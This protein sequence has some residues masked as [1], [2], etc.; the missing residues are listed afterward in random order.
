MLS[1]NAQ[2]HMIQMLD[3]EGKN[4]RKR[5]IQ[6]TFSHPVRILSLAGYSDLK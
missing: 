2:H 3:G 4:T 5:G 1:I 6:S